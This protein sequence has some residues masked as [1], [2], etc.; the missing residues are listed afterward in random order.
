MYRL[1]RSSRMSRCWSRSIMWIIM[2]CLLLR[3]NWGKALFD[4]EDQ[5]SH[6]N[7]NL[8]KYLKHIMTVLDGQIKKWIN[9]QVKLDQGWCIIRIILRYILGVMVYKWL[10]KTA[11]VNQSPQPSLNYLSWHWWRKRVTPEGRDSCRKAYLAT[12]VGLNRNQSQDQRVEILQT[13]AVSLT[14]KTLPF[15]ITNRKTHP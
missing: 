3:R 9:C 8:K 5:A 2:N 1:I 14:W 11:Q 12:R 15:S 10:I 7:P 4:S 6:K 13:R